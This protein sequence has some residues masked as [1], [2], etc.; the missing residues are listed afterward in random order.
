MD[1][2][3]RRRL[4]QAGVRSRVA[5]RNV[6]TDAHKSRRVAWCRE[7]AQ[8]D[9]STWL[10]SDEYSFELANCSTM[11]RAWVL[12]RVGEKYLKCC[13]LRAPVSSRQKLMIW[14]CIASNGQSV[15]RIL[16]RNV[17][18]AAYIGTL[19]ASL[20]P[21]VDDLPLAIS[22]NLT[23]Q[24]DNATPHTAF[25]TRQFLDRRGIRYA[26]WP[27]LSPDLNVI[28]NVWA[29]LKAYVRKSPAI[30]SGFRTIRDCR[31]AAHSDR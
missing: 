10:F 14:G 28:E 25:R 5:L 31:L 24:Q 2:T 17:D 16:R 3:V 4:L 30:T 19:R 18:T 12:R 11:N 22:G 8:T 27:A 29:M 15:V 1:R 20:L 9:F 13:V 21:L 7:H 23:F 26:H 6:L